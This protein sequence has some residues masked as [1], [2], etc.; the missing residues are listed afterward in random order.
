MTSYIGNPVRT[1]IDAEMFL[2]HIEPELRQVREMLYTLN[3][4][5]RY[6]SQRGE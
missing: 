4:I 1:I 2:E 6:R 5:R 3:E